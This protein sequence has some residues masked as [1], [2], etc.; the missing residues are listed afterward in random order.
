M[1]QDRIEK[2]VVETVNRTRQCALMYE[3]EKASGKADLQ[4]Y[5]Y[6]LDG[7]YVNGLGQLLRLLSGEP[8]IKGKKTIYSKIIEFYPPYQDENITSVH[9]AI[10]EKSVQH[11]LISVSAIRKSNM[12]S[13]EN[14]RTAIIRKFSAIGQFSNYELV[15]TEVRLSEFDNDRVDILAK[16]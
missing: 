4:L 13:E 7:I 12:P 5:Q 15:G 1:Y 10:I 11:Y 2:I 6:M 8:S 14:Y 16:C 3:E 9:N